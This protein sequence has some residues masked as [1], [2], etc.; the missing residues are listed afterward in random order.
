MLNPHPEQHR[1]PSGC[2][3]GNEEGDQGGVG[4]GLEDGSVPAPP[5]YPGH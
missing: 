4:G 2:L 3:M 1:A 5:E